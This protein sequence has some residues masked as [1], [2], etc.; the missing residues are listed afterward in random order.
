MKLTTTNISNIYKSLLT[1]FEW[2]EPLFSTE[3]HSHPEFELIYIK[4]GKGRRIIGNTI[5]EFNADELTLVGPGLPHVWLTDKTTLQKNDNCSKAIIV[6]FNH[7]IFADGFY[8]M[9]ET[10]ALQKLL[11]RAKSGIDITGKTK[12]KIVNKL[13]SLLKTNGFEKII[14]LLEILNIIAS[15]N[16]THCINT[17]AIEATKPVSGRLNDVFNFIDG[18]IDKNISLSTVAKMTSL[19]PES[20]CRFFK[21][22]TGKTFVDYVQE[23]RIQHASQLLLNTD[24]TS[25]E[26]AYQNGFKTAS[27]FNKLFKKITG[28][29]PTEYRKIAVSQY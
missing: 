26:I 13:V 29:C 18:N 19:T 7:T 20:F 6:T 27:G 28:Y 25:A 22:K 21:Q 9:K 3:F 8:E 2:D 5:E 24:L 12:G 10:A 4:Q 23:T 14:C 11:I 17:T 15:S 1:I 16:E